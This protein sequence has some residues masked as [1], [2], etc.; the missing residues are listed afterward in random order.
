MTSC[1]ACVD[2]ATCVDAVLPEGWRQT[3]HTRTTL[4]PLGVIAERVHMDDR[5]R[6]VPFR[7]ASAQHLTA[8]LTDAGHDLIVSE[9]LI[10][11]SWWALHLAGRDTL[12]HA[13]LDLAKQAAAWRIG[14]IAGQLAV[15]EKCPV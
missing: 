3:I 1:A 11:A 12:P 5:A 10:A 7:R 8:V 2:A 6:Y 14:Y 13:V 15:P 4:W 9:R